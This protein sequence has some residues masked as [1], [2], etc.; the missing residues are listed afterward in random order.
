MKTCMRFFL[1]CILC[2][3][4]NGCASTRFTTTMGQ[5]AIK[6]KVVVKF[7]VATLRYPKMPSRGA[8]VEGYLVD[9]SGVSRKI[10]EQELCAMVHASAVS[11]YPQ[12]FSNN[13]DGFP[14]HIV[15]N[16]RDRRTSWESF[17]LEVA[18]L[19]IMGG[20]LPLPFFEKG[21]FDVTTYAASG[22]KHRRIGSA[23]FLRKDYFWLTVFSPF[24]LIP[25]P[26]ESAKP[27]KSE[28]ALM[29][30]QTYSIGGKLT[31]EGFADSVAQTFQRSDLTPEINEYIKSQRKF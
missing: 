18:T 6:K 15:V 11:R 25:I 4:M 1:S 17:L 29:Y 22:D 23:S 3:Y 10:S 19:G 8:F 12:L 13:S 21:Q 26:G 16:G 31:I 14:L 9:A 27:K 24:G 30:T 7:R 2:S 20:I 28:V 5:Q